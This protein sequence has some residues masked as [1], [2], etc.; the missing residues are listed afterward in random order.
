[1][2]Q[3]ICPDPPSLHE[4]ESTLQLILPRVVRL[5]CNDELL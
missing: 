4:T 3:F 5:E 2:F 1:L